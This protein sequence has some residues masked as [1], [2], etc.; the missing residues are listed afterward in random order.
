MA[1]QFNEKGAVGGGV[2]GAGAGASFGPWGALI[3][4]G[5]GALMGGFM[6][7][8]DGKAT[9][10]LLNAL[11]QIR[12]IQVPSAESM[13]IELQ[14]YVQ[15]GILTPEEAQY[16]AANPTEFAK[17]KINPKG[18]ETQ[19][20][21]IDKLMQIANSGGMDPQEQAALDQT[22]RA[23][24]AQEKGQRSSILQN[25]A[26]RGMLNSGMTTAAQLDANAAGAA[27]ANQQALQARADAATR[28]MQA[29]TTAG[30]MGATLQGQDWQQAAQTASAADAINK[31][32]ASQQNETAQFNASNKNAAQG[33]NLANAQG[34]MNANV[35]ANNSNTTRNADLIQQNFTNQLNKSSAAAGM[36]QPL[37]GV[38]SQN[39]Q[40]QNAFMGN[41]IGAGATAFG[42]AYNANKQ[43]P[44]TTKP[45][46]GAHGG[47]VTDSGDII[48]YMRQKYPSEGVPVSGPDYVPDIYTDKDNRQQVTP[49]YLAQSGGEVP[50]NAPV[51]GDSPKNDIVPAVLS[52]GEI[53][54]PRTAAQS[55]DKVME[56]LRRIRKPEPRVEP[57]HVATVLEALHHIQGA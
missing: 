26:Q 50:G 48:N 41:L 18:E 56:F 6:G 29:L 28:A 7:G 46:T 24:N 45:A 4:G 53:V 43:K 39:S 34:I 23:L 51:A 12:Q 17:I 5:A 35:A 27:N 9:E 19:I 2:G 1:Q 54:I 49:S 37:A 21:A 31:F 33:A 25:A 47:E 42:N 15:A 13:Q 10:T 44:D 32:N 11:E 55:P 52:P 40:D 3:G 38:Q 36:A 8:D 30:S 22:V 14:Q 57:K 20:Q 16:Y